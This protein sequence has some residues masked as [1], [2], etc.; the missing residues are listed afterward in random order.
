MARKKKATKVVKVLKKKEEELTEE[1]KQELTN[2]VA[3]QVNNIMISVLP[4]STLKSMAVKKV[5]ILTALTNKESQF[6]DS[7][8]ILLKVK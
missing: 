2:L 5:K 6:L 8:D 1:R 4:I 7:L 3:D